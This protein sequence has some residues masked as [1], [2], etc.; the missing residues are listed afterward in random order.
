MKILVTG[1]TGFIGTHLI[2]R[3]VDEGHQVLCLAKDKRNSS[4]LESLQIETVI[5]DLNGDIDFQDVLEGIDMV[6]HLAGVTR[7]QNYQEY[8]EGNHLATKNLLKMCARYQKNLK[9]FV[10]VSSI[11]ACGP[12]L[13]GK[14]GL[15]ELPC[16]PVSLY[17]KSK[18]CAEQEVKKYKDVFPITIVRPSAVYGP[19]DRD[20]IKYISLIK[21]HF[22]LIIGFKKKHMNLIH[23]DDLIQGM[24]LA[25]FHPR[26]AGETFFLGNEKPYSTIELGNVIAS[27]LQCKRVRIFVPHLL[28]Y[29]IG[30]VSEMIGK[31]SGKPVFFNIQKVRD[32]V[33]P[34]WVFSPQK[35]KLMLGFQPRLTLFQG[36]QETTRWYKN[37]GWF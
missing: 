17:G 4:L 25:G 22:Q 33:Q 13:E 9:R 21:K 19:R 34:A 28:V 18:M 27:V 15:E 37:Q 10:Y 32:S 14:P 24:M 3:L 31:I 20:M 2:E 16:C 6:F 35:A 30:A 7:A 5:G 23:V 12:T 36:M 1:G 26:G 11:A 8:E 29:M